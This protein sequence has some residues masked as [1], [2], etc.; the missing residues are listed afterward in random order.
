MI[1]IF[2][3]NLSVGPPASMNRNDFFDPHTHIS[4]WVPSV[5]WRSVTSSNSVYYIVRQCISKK[6]CRCITMWDKA[7]DTVYNRRRLVSASR[8]G[9]DNLNRAARSGIQLRYMRVRIVYERPDCY[10]STATAELHSL[11]IELTLAG[12]GARAVRGNTQP[13][14]HKVN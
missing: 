3:E 12:N 5:I 14:R 13:A 6:D 10:V 2:I 7:I 8:F 11:T 1:W 9:R 4:A